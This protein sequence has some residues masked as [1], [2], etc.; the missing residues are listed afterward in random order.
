MNQVINVLLALVFLIALIFVTSYN[1]VVSLL[2]FNTVMEDPID[3]DIKLD[4]IG[5]NLY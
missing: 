3:M 5:E 4:G 2:S 1:K